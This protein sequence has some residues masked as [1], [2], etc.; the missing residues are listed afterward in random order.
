MTKL[1]DGS[2]TLATSLGDGAAQV[3]ETKASD[4]TISM[5]ATPITHDF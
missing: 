4:D 2:D 3:K 1:E 5:F